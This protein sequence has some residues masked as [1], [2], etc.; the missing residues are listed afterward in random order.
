MNI[1][2]A[3]DNLV[4]LNLLEKKL[5]QWGFEVRTAQ[6]GVEAWER[7]KSSPV[8]MVISDW[9]MPGMS[10][11]ELFQRIRDTG[12]TNYIYLI[13]V[14]VRDSKRDIVRGLEAG[15][16]DYIT[17][18][19][20]LK[21]FRSRVEIGARIVGLERELSDKYNIIK[22]NYFQTIH[23]FAN[24]LE[25]YDEE[26]GGHCRRVGRLALTLAMRHPAVS[27]KHYP[28]VEAAGLLH[29][30]GMVG[31]PIELLSKRRVEMNADEKQLYMSHPIQG[32]IILNEI[33]LL[34][35][36]AKLVRSHHEQYNGRG[37]PDRLA[38]VEIDL[39][40]RIVTAAVAYDHMVYKG[41]VSLED[42]PGSLNSM[43]GYQLDPDIVDYLLEINME[44]IQVE[45]EKNF[46]EVALDDLEEDMTLASDVRMKTGV[47]VMPVNTK[48]TGSGIEKL[49]S[50]H[51]LAC[52]DCKVRVKKDSLR[53]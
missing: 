53:E 21:E 9:M 50:Y 17:K 43:S 22:R 33:D 44:R 30:V 47:L 2:V 25:V 14:S 10:G 23:M 12:F 28:V 27:E 24:L 29:D 40:A 34:R 35:P 45:G 4:T 36:V 51:E 20:E 41:K 37:F 26:L 49:K 19:F 18:P 52:I 48:M 15:V 42:L 16:D 31:F 5:G 13:L 7:L 39:L 38:G 11:L 8:D 3:E 1:L 46:I 6:N 32:E